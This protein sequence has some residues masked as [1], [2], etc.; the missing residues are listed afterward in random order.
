MDFALARLMRGRPIG[1]AVAAFSQ[2]YADLSTDLLNLVEDVDET[3]L[4]PDP[5]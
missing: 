4:I 5:S 3:G 1:F 2:K